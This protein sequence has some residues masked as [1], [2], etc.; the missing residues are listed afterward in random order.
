MWMDLDSFANQTVNS[1]IQET[2]ANNMAEAIDMTS[3]MLR[4]ALQLNMNS[5]YAPHMPS[6]LGS[7]NF[8]ALV[9]TTQLLQET[10]KL[11]SKAA[12]AQVRE[13]EAQLDRAQARLI[14]AEAAYESWKA[15][16]TRESDEITGRDENERSQGT[17]ILPR[18]SPHIRA[19][20]SC[21]LALQFGTQLTRKLPSLQ[22]FLSVKALTS[23]SHLCHPRISDGLN[24]RRPFSREPTRRL[25]LSST[26]P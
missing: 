10:A 5:F 20:S 2:M 14:A 17:D 15:S 1:I 23:T 9:E 18:Y 26:S 11:Q 13:A 19:F 6:G 25:R 4:D 3:D 12:K 22:A 21:Q 24:P 7:Q 16:E 8:Q